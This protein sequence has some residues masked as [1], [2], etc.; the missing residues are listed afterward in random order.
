MQKIV[1]CG[2]LV[3]P[4]GLHTAKTDDITHTHT[5]HHTTH[6]HTYCVVMPY[7]TLR[8]AQLSSLISSLHPAKCCKSNSSYDDVTDLKGVHSQFE[9]V[10]LEPNPAYGAAAISKPTTETQCEEGGEEETSSEAVVEE[11]S[12]YQ[13]YI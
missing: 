3:R 2:L 8:Q 12:V 1:Y 9:D 6:D 5:P 13:V 7:S 4:C 10:T 11:D